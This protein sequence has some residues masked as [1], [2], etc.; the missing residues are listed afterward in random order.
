MNRTEFI[1]A[2]AIALFIA[3]LLGWF[4]HWLVHRLTRV[5]QADLDELESMA[6]SL[7]DAEETRD[8]ALAHLSAREEEMR[9]ESEGREAE[10]MA[11]MDAVR[12]AREE[13]ER[14]RHRLGEH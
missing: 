9:H 10:L 12:Q 5:S 2:T 7:H 11:A 4:A 13:N 1:I 8:A 3:F 6:Q 14:L